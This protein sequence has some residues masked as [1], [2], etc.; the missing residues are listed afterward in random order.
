MKLTPGLAVVVFGIL[1]WICYSNNT[2][3]ETSIGDREGDANVRGENGF[4]EK[5]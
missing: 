5:A 3:A 2:H 4:R 1:T